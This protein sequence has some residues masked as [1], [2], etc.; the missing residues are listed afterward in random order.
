MTGEE[1]DCRQDPSFASCFSIGFP[2]KFP[3]GYTTRFSLL[4]R[5]WNASSFFRPSAVRNN[6]PLRQRLWMSAILMC[7]ALDGFCSI[8]GGSLAT[9]RSGPGP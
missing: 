1:L 4:L 7:S 9:S 8:E 3:D 5:W 2:F 6:G